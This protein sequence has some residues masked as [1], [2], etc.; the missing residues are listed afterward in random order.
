MVKK[1]YAHLVKP[2]RVQE[3]PPGLYA[4]PRVWMDAKDLEGFQAHFTYGVFKEPCVCHPIEGAVVHP[5]DECLVFAGTD[6]PD[7]RYLGAEISIE[8]GE[9]REEYVFDTPKAIAI[10]KGTPH[11]PVTIRRMDKPIMHWGFGLAPEYRAENPSKEGQNDG[12]STRP[13]HQ[14][15]AHT[16]HA[17]LAGHRAGISDHRRPGWGPSPVREGCRPG[18]RRPAHLAVRERP[19]RNG[20]QLRLW[21][22]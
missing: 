2:L 16:A 12:V 7:I 6:A 8:L 3:T 11:G 4:Q 1:E 14:E 9:E 22:L 20:G 5:Y 13:P 18:K 17:E 21:L 15:P 19:R 10:P